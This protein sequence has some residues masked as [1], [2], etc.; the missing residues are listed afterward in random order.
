MSDTL[1]LRLLG[2]AALLGLLG[3]WLVRAEPWGLNVVVGTT[4]LAVAAASLVP[5]GR[6]GA[7]SARRLLLVPPLFAGAVAWREA[8]LLSVWNLL[9]VAGT[10]TLPVIRI[11]GVR[12]VTGRSLDYALGA[13]TTGLRMALGP[14]QLIATDVSWNN[15]M[16][17]AKRRRFTTLALGCGLA[18]PL[19]VIFGALLVS[20]DAGFERLVRT[21]FDLDLQALLSHVFGIGFIGWVSS[22]YLVAVLVGIREPPTPWA[23]GFRPALGAVE[24]GIPLGGLALLFSVFVVMQA[25]YVF[26]GQDLIRETANLGYADYARRGFFELVAVAVLILPVLLGVDLVADEDI[27]VQQIVRGGS[28][29]LLL[30]VGLIMLSALHRMGLYLDAYGLTQ[31]R[32]YATG[33]LLWAAVAIAWF[34]VTVLKGKAERFLFGAVVSA[35][36]VLSLLNVINVDAMIVRSNVARVRAGA[37]LDAEYLASLSADA[38]PALVQALPNMSDEAACI[39]LEALAPE[40]G[41]AEN[42]DWRTWH[43][44][45]MWAGQATAGLERI[46]VARCALRNGMSL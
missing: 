8:G 12:L 37:E 24:L 30:L 18:V 7:G 15:V 33:A 20:A 27:S 14:L 9:A 3:D 28:A 22:G 4:A 2:S 17:P 10:L 46:R 6:F 35:L 41:V 25:G 43:I 11:G 19:L 39:V 31:D 32:V 38:V 16:D 13:I 34:A 45:R 29:A 36:A 40:G 44:S 42:R 23:A 21:V 1:S 26:G 5:E